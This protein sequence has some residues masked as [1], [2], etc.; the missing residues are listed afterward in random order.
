[1]FDKLSDGPIKTAINQAIADLK[2]DK[3]I[4]EHVKKKQIPKYYVTKHNI[5]ILYRYALPNRWRLIYS[6]IEFEVK[7]ELSILLLELM[8]HDSYNKR[9]GYYKK[10]SA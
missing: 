9:F 3:I 4:G 1:M 6:I 2:Q 5:S 7:G 10:K 8:N